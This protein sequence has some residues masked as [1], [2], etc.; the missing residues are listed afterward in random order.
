MANT[1]IL[2]ECPECGSEEIYKSDDF[3]FD[4]DELILNVECDDCGYSWREIYSFSRN[5]FDEISED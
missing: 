5:D 1:K 4:Y 3:E 2:K